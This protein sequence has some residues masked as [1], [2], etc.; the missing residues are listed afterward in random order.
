TARPVGVA[1]GVKPAKA[2]TSRTSAALPLSRSGAPRC[3]IRR[4]RY[5]RVSTGDQ[6]SPTSVH[7]ATSSS[8]D[9]SIF[10]AP[11]HRRPLEY[12]SQRVGYSLVTLRLR[13]ASGVPGLL[14]GRRG[15]HL[16]HLA[17]RRSPW[18]A[19]IPPCSPKMLH[20]SR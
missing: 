9:H 17:N 20:T 10:M 3:P 1:D 7:D 19:W 18:S 13:T 14:R 5:M 11:D 15:G 12:S 8:S 16:S 2:P 6:S 4:Y